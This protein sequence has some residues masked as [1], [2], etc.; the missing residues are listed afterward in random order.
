VDGGITGSFLIQCG[1]GKMNLT[2]AASDKRFCKLE[3]NDACEVCVS[4]VLHRLE[5]LIERDARYLLWRGVVR[6]TLRYMR[7]WMAA[8][9]LRRWLVGLKLLQTNKKDSSQHPSLSP[10]CMSYWF[11]LL[12]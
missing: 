9:S 12:P 4:C 2:S 3:S 10:A 1:S 8:V 7:A 11:T 6:A 5:T